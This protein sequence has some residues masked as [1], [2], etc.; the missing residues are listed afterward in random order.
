M[1][2]RWRRLMEL[3]NG[4]LNVSFSMMIRGKSPSGYLEN[5]LGNSKGK[6]SLESGNRQIHMIG[7]GLPGQVGPHYGVRPRDI[8]AR[9]KECEMIFKAAAEF[10][11]GLCERLRADFG[12]PL[13]T[14][15]QARRELVKIFSIRNARTDHKMEGFEQII[16]N[17]QDGPLQRMESPAE[18]ANRLREGL[19]FTP[20]SPEII[21]AFYEHT[22]RMRPVED[23]GHIYFTHEG[24]LLEFVP[25]SISQK[26]NAGT[27]TLC[28]YHPD[29]PRFLHLTDGKGSILGTWLRKALVKSGDRIALT[30]AMHVQASA[31]KAAKDRAAQLNAGE[32][33][34]LTEM[35]ERNAQLLNESG[36]VDVTDARPTLA[37]ARHSALES[38]VAS[39][40]TSVRAIAEEKE[41]SR[42]RRS[43]LRETRRRRRRRRYFVRVR[44]D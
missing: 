39:G 31:L 41:S 14:I 26:L 27:K 11:A 24:R 4:R 7:S 10:P 20:V 6:A 15:Q 16:V 19:Q 13:L 17:G 9:E 5:A 29:D 30:E 8:A 38:P 32:V 42:A 37:D 18:R 36:F 2:A 34:R 21:A 23:D 40:L 33:T 43:P 1:M 3:L 22:Q 35:R 25:P 12:Y 44:T 28:Y